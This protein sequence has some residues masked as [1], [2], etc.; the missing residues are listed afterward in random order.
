MTP[1]RYTVISQPKPKDPTRRQS[2][3]PTSPPIVRSAREL[4]EERE[5]EA[6]ALEPDVFTMYEAVPIG[7]D[8]EMASFL[9]MLQEYLRGLLPHIQPPLL[10]ID[11]FPHFLFCVQ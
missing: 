2:V 7:D 9:P 8:P 10:S 3:A 11:S 1:R 4:Q 6:K 5:R